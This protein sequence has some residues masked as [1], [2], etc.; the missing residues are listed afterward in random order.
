MSNSENVNS[1]VKIKC[2]SNKSA[3]DY[4]SKDVNKYI[5]KIIIM[6]KEKENNTGLIMI[7]KDAFDKNRSNTLV[8]LQVL[9]NN[10]CEYVLSLTYINNNNI[11][12][13]FNNPNEW[14]HLHFFN[15]QY[16]SKTIIEK[17]FEF[18]LDIIYK[19]LQN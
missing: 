17:K 11:S 15:D 4:K 7:I 3:I 10:V 14:T 18:N 1:K 6:L 5:D 19:H 16:V 12:K 2:H 13:D 8:S 9:L